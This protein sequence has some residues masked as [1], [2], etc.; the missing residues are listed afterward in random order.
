MRYSALSAERLEA[1]LDG[2]DRDL[3]A[4]LEAEF[5]QDVLDVIRNR[6]LGNAGDDL[7]LAASDM[8]DFFGDALSSTSFSLSGHLLEQFG[9]VGHHA[10]PVRDGG[11][12]L[13]ILLGEEVY[14]LGVG[15]QCPAPLAIDGQRDIHSTV[16]TEMLEGAT[17][18]IGILIDLAVQ[19]RLTR[20]IHADYR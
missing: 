2:P 18:P 9:A 11:E 12:E 3:G 20:L 19:V 4:G 6:A 15:L 13:E 5:A 8:A 7:A 1:V 16:N 10:D 17:D 14:L